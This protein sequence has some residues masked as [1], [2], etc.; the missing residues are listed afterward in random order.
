[1]R[2]RWKSWGAW[3]SG[4]LDALRCDTPLTAPGGYWSRRAAKPGH[5][6][7]HLPAATDIA[8]KSSQ[9]IFGNPPRLDWAKQS[10]ARDAWDSMSQELGWA[11]KLVEGGEVDSATG[12]VYWRPQWDTELAD[13]PLLTMVR[14]DEAIP[15]FAYDM[16]RT[17]TFVTELET[18]DKN[19]TLRWLEHHEPGQIRHELWRGTNTTIGRLIPLTEHEATRYLIPVIDTT[20]IRPTGILVEYTPNDLPQPLS[21]QPYGRADIQGGETFLDMLDGAW[22]AWMHD[23]DVGKGR[24]IAPSE[25]LD[26]LNA[27]GAGGLGGVASRFFGRA[28]SNTTAAKAFDMDAD[29]FT[30]IPG[31]PADDNGKA[32]PLT[33]VQFDIRYQ[34]LAA[35]CAAILEQVVSRAGYAPQTFGLQVDGELSGTA[36]RRR[37]RASHETKNKKRQ[38]LKPGLE[39]LA[40]TLMLINHVAFNG[41]K[42]EAKP[43]LEW[44]ETDTSDPVET[45]QTIELLRRAQAA[46]TVTVVKMQHPDWDDTQVKEEVARIVAENPV[47]PTITGFEPVEPPD[48]QE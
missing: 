13:H 31:M 24:V 48:E 33:V 42:P 27:P 46:S 2:T 37:E 44:R 12:G 1:M 34:A 25:Y 19:D 47:A 7:V 21:R 5:R 22:A 14:A 41:P 11:R 32:A 16:L 6:E 17:V 38:Y 15:T 36:I 20:S 8:R 23:L 18:G 29:V 43:T 26:P 28:T 30:P 40:E 39:R 45:S 3:W 9:L 35:T 4:D 10:K